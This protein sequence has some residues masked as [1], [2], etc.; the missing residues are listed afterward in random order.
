MSALGQEGQKVLISLFS[1]GSKPNLEAGKAQGY[2]TRG[3][4]MWPPGLGE[5]PYGQ[6][7]GGVKLVHG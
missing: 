4:S 3:G 6:V 1:K 7:G 2:H 5:A